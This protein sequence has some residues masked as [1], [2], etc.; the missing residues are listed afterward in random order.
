MMI[1]TVKI[2]ENIKMIKNNYLMI[3]HSMEI[4]TMIS[5][6]KMIRDLPEKLLILALIL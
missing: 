4:P 3:T 2:Q 5:S 6:T 1:M